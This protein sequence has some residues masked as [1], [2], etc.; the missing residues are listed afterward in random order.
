MTLNKQKGNMYG[1][2][3]HTWNPIKGRCLHNCTYCFMQPKW[4]YLESIGKDMTLRLDHKEFGTDLG[5]GNFI[6]IGSST[7]MWTFEIVDVW[8]YQIF[9][10]IREFPDNTY[11]F[12]TKH[13][14]GFFDMQPFWE[15][16]KNIILGITLETNR[17]HAAISNAMDPIRRVAAFAEIEHARKMVTIEPIMDFDLPVLTAMIKTIDPEL[18]TIGGDSQGHDLPE[19]SKEKIKELTERLIGFTEVLYKSNLKRL[20]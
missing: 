20:L 13:P 15:G 11:L 14:I 2:V 4:K 8:Q 18:V 17:I 5:S 10:H 7:D 19:P 1:F 9:K 6:F 3:T 12:Q 16:A